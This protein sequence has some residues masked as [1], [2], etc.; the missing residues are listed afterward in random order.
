MAHPRGCVQGRPHPPGGLAGGLAAAGDTR[1]RRAA[2]AQ[3]VLLVRDVEHH[4]Q[5]GVFEGVQPPQGQAATAKV[6]RGHMGER[7]GWVGGVL[8]EGAAAKAAQA[9]WG[10]W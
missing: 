8:G 7:F 10:G 5:V 4:A 3:L 2:A 1:R 9:R 6:G